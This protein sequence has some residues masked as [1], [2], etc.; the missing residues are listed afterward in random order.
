[1]LWVSAALFAALF[2]RPVNDLAGGPSVFE[3]RPWH[4]L[5][6]AARDHD[7]TVCSRDGDWQGWLDDP[8][9]AATGAFSL[10]SANT[11]GHLVYKKLKNKSS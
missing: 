11:A 4:A 9:A 5:Q 7:H 6:P 1:M 8:D 3:V 10:P 2:Q